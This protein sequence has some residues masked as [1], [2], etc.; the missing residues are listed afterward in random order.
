MRR[1]SSFLFVTAGSAAL[2]VAMLAGPGCGTGTTSDDAGASAHDGANYFEASTSD[3]GAL[4][5]CPI[6][7][8]GKATTKHPACDVCLA[9]G[10]CNQATACFGDPTCIDLNN[11]VGRC[12]SVDAGGDAQ[13]Q[14]DCASACYAAHSQTA[15]DAYQAFVAC[16]EGPCGATCP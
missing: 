7:K 14:L 13:A 15:N 5:A 16:L 4:A 6:F 9:N 11:C 8:E 12:A 1:A 10:C 2:F 3:D